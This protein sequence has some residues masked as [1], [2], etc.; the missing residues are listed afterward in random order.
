MEYVGMKY[1]AWG[2]MGMKCVEIMMPQNNPGR[3]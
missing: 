2:Y 3:G 1:V